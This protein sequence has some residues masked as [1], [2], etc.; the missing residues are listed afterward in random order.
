MGA[1]ALDPTTAAA[2]RAILGLRLVDGID[3]SV[4]GA[5][6]AIEEGLAWAAANDLA[7]RVD[8]RVRLTPRG[9]LLSNEVF[10]RL[11]PDPDRTPVPTKPAEA[12]PVA[13]T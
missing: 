3:E 8:D 10:A 5:H 4:A 11:L 6:P 1:S 7:E 9:R 13:A 2:E 12:V